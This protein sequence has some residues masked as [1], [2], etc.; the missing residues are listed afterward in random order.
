MCERNVNVETNDSFF[1]MICTLL[2]FVQNSLE[3]VFFD[4]FLAATSLS[5]LEI[6]YILRSTEI[7]ISVCNILQKDRQKECNFIS[8]DVIYSKVS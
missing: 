8:F 2:D 6:S 5:V 1:F 7:T 4:I 3:K